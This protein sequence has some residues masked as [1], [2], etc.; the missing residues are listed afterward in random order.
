MSCPGPDRVPATTAPQGVITAP[1]SG[2]GAGPLLG[3]AAWGQALGQ[4]GGISGFGEVAPTAITLGEIAGAPM[5]TSIT[6]SDWGAPQA[7]GQGQSIDGTGQTGPI[8]S[9]PEA[10]VTVV[11]FDLGS[12]DGAPPPQEVTWYFPQ[13]GQTFDPT[14]ATNAC[15]GQ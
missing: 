8:S 3:D 13:H 9:W 12:C 10:P 4:F 7:T 6:W 2:G 11:A 1:P 15:T 5:V 14:R